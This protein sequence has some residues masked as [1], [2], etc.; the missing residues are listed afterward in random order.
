MTPRPHNLVGF[1]IGWLERADPNVQ[2]GVKAATTPL[3]RWVHEP[4]PA[5]G[6]DHL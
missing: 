4:C 5:E 6:H 2:G 3:T 1:P